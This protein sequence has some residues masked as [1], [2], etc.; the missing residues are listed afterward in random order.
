MLTLTPY[1]ASNAANIHHRVPSIDCDPEVS[2][3]G[4]WLAESTI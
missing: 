3:R 1:P 2:Y 4:L